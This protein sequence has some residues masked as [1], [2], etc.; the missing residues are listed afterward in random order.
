[1]TELVQQ[2]VH[3]RVGSQ[4]DLPSYNAGLRPV[5]GKPAASHVTDMP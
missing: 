1:V 2:R 3:R 5:T 4:V